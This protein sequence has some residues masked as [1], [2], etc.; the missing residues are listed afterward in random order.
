MFDFSLY[1][2]S[3]AIAKIPKPVIYKLC[4][5]VFCILTFIVGFPV[6]LTDTTQ[7]LLT[8]KN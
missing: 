1:S 4:K 6:H 5:V 2:I 8:Q 7:M 3:F